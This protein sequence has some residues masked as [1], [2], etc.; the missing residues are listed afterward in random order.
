MIYIAIVA[1]IVFIGFLVAN[2]L[3][4][5]AKP[6]LPPEEHYTDDDFD[7]VSIKISKENDTK[8]KM[9][10]MMDYIEKHK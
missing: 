9:K 7:D 4:V 10:I 2:Y 6:D 8:K 3:I 5:T 1:A